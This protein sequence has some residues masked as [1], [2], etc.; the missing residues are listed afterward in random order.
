MKKMTMNEVEY[1]RFTDWLDRVLKDEYKTERF[2]NTA[3]EFASSIN[4]CGG[5]FELAAQ[6]SKMSGAC[7]Y[8]HP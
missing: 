3:W 6:F 8:T 1:L 7:L 5:Q 4:D 2:I